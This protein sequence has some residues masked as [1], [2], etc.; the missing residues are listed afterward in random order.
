MTE[1]ISFFSPN[2][3]S[4]LYQ[5]LLT[6]FNI[7]CVLGTGFLL[8]FF[9]RGCLKKRNP[10]YRETPAKAFM[11][12]TVSFLVIALFNVIFVILFERKSM[13]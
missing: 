5:G 3:T 6:S 10:K 9:L 12:L 4:G 11:L 13:H 8:R 2:L 1:I 7:L